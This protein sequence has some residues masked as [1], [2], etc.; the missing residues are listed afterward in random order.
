[1][2]NLPPFNRDCPADLQT[3]EI[4]RL[5][6]ATG[7]LTK[8]IR[9]SDDG[10]L[11]S[12][13]SA[14]LMGRG[15][16]RRLRFAG[17]GAFASLLETL[18]TNEA[19]ALGAL[20]AELPDEVEIT[21]QKKLAAL[22]GH[23]P[24][25][26]IARTAGHITYRPDRPALALIDIDTKGMPPAVAER[27]RRVGGYWAALA[28]VVP[29]L[30]YVARA[31]RTSTSSGISRADTGEALRGSNGVHV[32]LLVRDG[33][34][35]ERFLRTLHDR[36]WLAGF[37]WLMVGAGGQLL[38]RSL[39]DRTV[40]A[41]ERLVFEAA[42]ILDEPLR[43]D[44]ARRA[45]SVIEGEPADTR[46]IC[47]N[48]SAAEQ[49]RLRDAKAAER[50]RLARPATEA[51]RAF[52][53]AQANRIVERTGC[54]V[55]E[56]KRTI[57]RQCA[58]ILLP[59]VILP[60]DADELHGTT[61][62]DVLNDPDRF[63]GLTLADPLEGPDYGSCKAKIMRRPDGAIWIN[64][65]AHG[66][67][68]Y[69][70]RHD[71]TSIEKQIVKAE[72]AAVNNL[73]VSLLLAS[74][75]AADEET[76]L[77]D[78]VRSISGVKARPLD[79][80]VKAARKE[81]AA[82]LVTAEREHR[83]AH[84]AD[85]RLSVP[86]PLPDA[87]RLPVMRLLDEALTEADRAV[88]PIRDL[89]GH[90]VEVRCRPPMMLHELTSEGSNQ[91]EPTKTRLPPPAL[92]LLTRHDRYSL[93]HEIE[94]HLEFTVETESAGT[95]TVA[96][97]GTFIDHFIAYRNSKL[98]RVGAIV[99][100]PLVLMDGTLLA[101][102]GLDRDR[103]LVFQ[104]E[105]QLI[106]LLPDPL[107]ATDDAAAD[108]LN[109]LANQWL[110]DVAADFAGKC[111]LIAMA[112][113]IIERVLLPER[114]AFFVT[115][116]K[117]G[118]GK[119][120]AI[121]MV[122]LA[123]TGKKPAAAAWSPN[124]E[125]RRKAIL[126]YLAEG[127]AAMVWDNIPLGTT[128][129]CPTLEKVL[130]AESYSDR[131]LGQST[132]ITVPSFTVMAFTGN[133]IGPKGD[134][135]SR[136]LITRLEVDRID[137]ENRRF[138]HSDPVAWTLE[139]RGA[140]LRALYTILLASPQLRADTRQQPRTRFKTWWHLVGAG[141]ESAAATLA[142]RQADQAAGA[143]AATEID[144]G[145]LFAMVED[146]DEEGAVL[147]DVVDILNRVWSGKCFQ[148][149]DVARFINEPMQDEAHDAATLSAFFEPNG[150]RAGGQVSPR[151]IGK[152]LVAMTGAPV[153]VGGSTMRLDR[154]APRNQQQRKQAL[155]FG[156][157]TL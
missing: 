108:A 135:A 125:E 78:L 27:I 67:T 123:V 54:A 107:L 49:A 114:P 66:R 59:N 26:L 144:F 132:T 119:T 45:P 40:Y 16:A 80:K 69:E 143:G 110:C 34:D 10:A 85:G 68:T 102:R 93:A 62:A 53:T 152:R 38:E 151:A 35:V 17:L 79:A 56:A 118:G 140:I 141:V 21:T 153:S 104:I 94:Q 126:A 105:P 155:W 138:T 31:V 36:C 113:T 90:P 149:A 99:T 83:A 137:P 89:D 115:A 20:A 22:N 121:M 55:E 124:E 14:C 72:P 58:G 42:P 134:M 97:P 25:N 120:T 116:G 122:I 63:V 6:S 43:Q 154:I 81:Q 128:I 75:L 95:R 4:T 73:F 77:R 157:S 147:A 100:T 3:V 19:I 2:S 32:F 29:D 142:K 109:F 61:V 70:L 57:E 65:F 15:E 41:A 148:A 30:D 18:E 52:V 44:R 92:P 139:N 39:I 145:R 127:L 51:R 98:P 156:I 37:G 12:D 133:N 71:F 48:L 46:N 117:R 88:P 1:M 74:D 146:D 84:R 82:Q 101:P 106:P 11:I 8:R 5:A 50:E 86:A 111:V 23:A 129:A 87:E 112:L 64:S 9:L 131:V 60:F 24:S 150:R 76:R 130:T 91:N 47:R 28:S 136:S 13:G 33:G 7:P 96:L 103:K